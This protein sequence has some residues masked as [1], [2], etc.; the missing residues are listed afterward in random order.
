MAD[1]DEAPRAFRI[2]VP[3]NSDDDLDIRV[4]VFKDGKLQEVALEDMPDEVL[5]PFEAFFTKLGE[6]TKH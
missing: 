3:E 1:E 5:A 4:Q 2:M 6:E